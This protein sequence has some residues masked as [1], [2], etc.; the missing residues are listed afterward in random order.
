MKEVLITNSLITG[1]GLIIEQVQGVHNAIAKIRFRLNNETTGVKIA[2]GGICR[3]SSHTCRK[4][5]TVKEAINV[6][7]DEHIRIQQDYLLKLRRRKNAKL[8]E[9]SVPVTKSSGIVKPSNG[10]G[11]LNSLYLPDKRA[12][13]FNDRALAPPTFGVTNTTS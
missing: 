5:G 4:M 3:L 13:G 10:L 7:N 2:P 12:L 6:S 1:Q 11:R 9:R 8:R